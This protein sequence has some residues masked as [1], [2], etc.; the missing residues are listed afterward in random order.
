MRLGEFLIYNNGFNLLSFTNKTGEEM[1]EVSC[2][3]QRMELTIEEYDSVL[4]KIENRSKVNFT[5]RKIMKIVKQILN[6]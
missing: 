1:I 5:G 6:I 2:K 4:S 3:S